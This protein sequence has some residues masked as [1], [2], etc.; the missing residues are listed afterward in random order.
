VYRGTHSSPFQTPQSGNGTK[1]SSSI[2]IGFKAQGTLGSVGT[3][4]IRRE[5]NWGLPLSG[6]GARKSLEASTQRAHCE[7]LAASFF[8]RSMGSE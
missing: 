5:K 3:L 2:F 4:S 8:P 6:G 1:N 7:L